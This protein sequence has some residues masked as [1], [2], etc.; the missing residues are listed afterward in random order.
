ML[1]GKEQKQMLQIR[2]E[3]GEAFWV[4]TENYSQMRREGF[5]SCAFNFLP[6]ISRKVE[7]FTPEYRKIYF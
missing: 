6:G 1:S 5:L 4:S 7:T 2:P 3:A